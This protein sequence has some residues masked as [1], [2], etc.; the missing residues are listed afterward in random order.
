M[1]YIYIILIASLTALYAEE[2]SAERSK[3]TIILD[4]TKVKNLG[5]Q[6]AEVEEDTF[7]ETYMAL[8][9]L[10]AIPQKSAVVSAKISGRVTEL[11]HYINEKVTVGQSLLRL[12]SFLPGSPPPTI[13]IS[14]PVSGTIIHSEVSLGS[15]VEQAD[16]LMGITDLSS[17]WA[18]AELP[19]E[20]AVGFTPETQS[21]ILILSSPDKVL[22]GTFVSFYP[23]ADAKSGTV[24]A[25]F[26][27]GNTDLSLRPGLQAEFQ[28]IRK[29]YEDVM[30]VPT[31]AIQGDLQDKYVYVEDFELD[32]S[33]IKAPIVIGKQNGRFTEIKSGLFPGDQVV[34]KGA[35][36]LSTSSGGSMSLKEALDTAHG[37]EHNEDG[38]PVT[39]EQRA[40]RV[41]AKGGGHD[42]QNEGG[43][44]PLWKYLTFGLGAL[45][46]A[47]LLQIISTAQKTR[48]KSL[49]EEEPEQLVE[50]KQEENN[51]EGA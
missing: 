12:E 15:S 41:A 32:Y 27:I 2:G 5:I 26:L 21:E 49:T 50:S 35:Y 51:H 46:F 44:N 11:N 18:V 24:K 36:F 4:Q 39:D 3:N 43:G 23:E 28:I 1:K 31:A 37:H 47:L 45:S 16:S 34:T 48:K 22:K 30:M 13:T 25:V 20:E 38:T 6:L 9:A 40:E 7:R 17:L 14:S 33:Y 42:D 29:T 19:Q 8:G 10:E